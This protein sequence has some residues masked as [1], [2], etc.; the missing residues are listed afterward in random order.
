MSTSITLIILKLYKA[1]SASLYSA[2]TKQSQAVTRKHHQDIYGSLVFP[3][4]AFLTM[5]VFLQ[6]HCEQRSTKTSCKEVLEALVREMS[7][8]GGGVG[9]GNGGGKY[10]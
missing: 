2:L 5:M 1:H 8:C 3:K 9:L 4:L 7:T 10:R 6:S